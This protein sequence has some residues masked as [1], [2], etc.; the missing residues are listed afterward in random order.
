MGKW[1]LKQNN[2]NIGLA[3]ELSLPT[4]I[5]QLLANRG[6]TTKNEIEYFL[7]PSVDKLLDPFLLHGMK[8]AV[9]KIKSH[10]SKGNRITIMG[11]F[12]VDGITSTTV[13]LKVFKERLKYNS[14][15]YYIPNRLKEG[16]GLSKQAIDIMQMFG[17]DLIITV[18]NGISAVKEVEYA[19]S[20][21][22]DIITSDHHSPQ[23]KLPECI[24]V[25]PKHP[26]CTYPNK[27]LA[28]CGVAFK[29][30]C[31]LDPTLVESDEL[32]EYLN[33]VAFGSIAD[34]VTL[35]GENRVIAYNGCLEMGLSKN[36]GLRK[37]I[38]KSDIK[39]VKITAGQVGFNLAP[40]INAIGRVGKADLGVELFMS[41]DESDVERLVD[42]L[43][44]QNQ[45]RQEIENLMIDQAIDTI[46]SSEELKN[47]KIL[48]I[49]KDDWHD[50]IIGIAASKICD[51]YHKPTILIS[52]NKEGI[53]KGSARSIKGF[54]VF[55]AVC[56]V[57]DLMMS[58]GGHTMASGLK[59][60]KDN[61][62]EFIRRVTE[63]ANENITDDMLKKQINVDCVLSEN[64]LTL[65]L[66]ESISLLE[67]FGVGNF[68][69][70]FEI[71]NQT[72]ASKQLLGKLQN[73]CK[74]KTNNKFD[75]LAFNETLDNVGLYDTLDIVGNISINE[76]RGNKSVQLIA[77]D[78]RLHG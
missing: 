52:I 23:S 74:L 26:D 42:E 33:I 9:E 44:Y 68:T 77:R 50:G 36:L 7:N 48:I 29:I 53:C 78:W 62:G 71:D 64:D 41:K 2:I 54:S 32:S 31:A 47:G 61:L 27:E 15:D 46:E 24:I 40:K 73:H 3:E 38:E 55:E 22:I 72:V 4:S 66:A 56:S 59:L 63:Y 37:L 1:E 45:K 10:M 5:I 25:N 70:I 34:V 14:V 28:G 21:G 43:I 11:D 57:D 16:Y 49:A 67:P 17:T 18:D 39:D 8:D 19:K 12:D 76:F 51:K 75:I 20:L 65:E 60:H 30:A 58:H 13:M 35:T 69:P 6:V